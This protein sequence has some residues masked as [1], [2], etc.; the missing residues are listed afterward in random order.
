MSRCCRDWHEAPNS[1]EQRQVCLLLHHPRVREVASFPLVGVD[2]V[3]QVPRSCRVR[4]VV[5]LEHS[6]TRV[7]SSKRRA[8]QLPPVAENR[9]R[10]PS[11]MK[12][13]S[14]MRL[15]QFLAVASTGLLLLRNHQE[16]RHLARH[17]R[18]YW[19]LFSTYP[20][21]ALL[22]WGWILW[23]VS[24]LDS[25]NKIHL[26]PLKLVVGVLVLFL[27]S[28]LKHLHKSL[29]TRLEQLP[30]NSTRTL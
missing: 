10:F 18:L 30:L 27:S 22:L 6:V 24:D 28:Q 25:H 14:S 23:L 1:N 9:H 11:K 12:S 2:S 26:T 19:A 29:R 21:L 8:G 20:L 16:L 3:S 7:F 5:D 17:G 4:G 15:L 13:Q